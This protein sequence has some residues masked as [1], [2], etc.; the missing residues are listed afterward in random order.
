MYG[1]YCVLLMCLFLIGSNVRKFAKN[2]KIKGSVRFKMM[3]SSLYGMFH[4]GDEIG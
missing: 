1:G 3:R 2:D 4:S